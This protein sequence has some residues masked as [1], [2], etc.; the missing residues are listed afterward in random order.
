MLAR[1]TKLRHPSGQHLDT[2][3]LVPSFSS[4]GFGFHGKN[5]SEVSE[6]SEAFATAQEFL[7]ESL[8]L[9]AYDLFYGHIPKQE[10]SPVEITFVDSG[11]YETV[12][13]HDSSSVY[14]YPWPVR[15]WD[16]EKLRSVYDSWSDAVPAVFVSYDHGRVRKPL[17]NQ[18]ES[19]KELLA[20]YP[21]Q[22]H[23][24]ILK[25]E[26][27][28]QTQIQLPNTIGM[29]HE[30]GQFDIVGVTE[31]ELGNSL[32]TR[33]H[34]V[35]KL[36]LALD[37]ENITAPIQ[38]FGSLDPI[39]SSLYFLAGAEIFDG[40]TWLRYAYRDGKTI[41]QSNYGAL[42]G[43]KIIDTQVK[44]TVLRDNVYYL[45][46]LELQMKSFLLERDFQKFN[47]NAR[48][49]EQSYDALCSKLGGRL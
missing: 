23:D 37:Q 41:Y 18:L 44:A 48:L 46:N 32:L 33:M 45:E 10:T 27:D 3:A 43:L 1:S 42:E 40:L 4:K 25:P 19:A 8:L 38:V 5:G 16:E 15:E 21:R 2:P 14:T 26:K 24:F 6:V 12:D 29:I 22:L 7:C 34:N 49:L 17:K 11:G 28:T 13:M 47:Q 39:T 20:R 30:L 9:S 35:A 36:R 31:K